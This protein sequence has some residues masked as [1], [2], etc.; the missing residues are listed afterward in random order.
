MARA[1]LIDWKVTV[2]ASVQVSGEVPLGAIFRRLL[3]KG[4]RVWAQLGTKLW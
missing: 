2:A 1:S 3:C 4:C